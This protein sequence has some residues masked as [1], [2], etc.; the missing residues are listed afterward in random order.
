MLP[1]FPPVSD[2]V[3]MLSMISDVLNFLKDQENEN[4]HFA[5]VVA[6][7]YLINSV[8]TH[9]VAIIFHLLKLSIIVL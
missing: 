3:S 4:H 2:L 7:C 1:Y 9:I 5:V 6:N 8:S